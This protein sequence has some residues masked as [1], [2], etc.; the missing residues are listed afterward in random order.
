MTK[1]LLLTMIFLALLVP[2]SFQG[3]RG[4]YETSEGR[5]AECAREMI[6]KGDFLNPTLDYQPH[7]TKPPLTYWT[8][9][10]GIK[11]LGPGEW[12]IRLYASLAFALTALAVAFIGVI[13]WDKTTGFLAGIIYLTS[14]YPA[15]GASTLTTDMLL[16]LWETLAVLCYLRSFRTESSQEGEI[17]I[18]AMWVCFG[19]GFLTKGPPALIPLLPIITW[20]LWHKPETRLSSMKGFLLFAVVGVSW[21]VYVVVRNP[22]LVSYFLGQEVVDRVASSTVHNHEWY[23]PVTMYLPVLI[24]GAGVWLY[25][26]LGTVFQ[27]RIVYPRV[28]WSHLRRGASG[29]FLFFWLV[30]PLILFS[31]V[32]SRL[33]LYV[34]PLYA[35]VALAIAR[36]LGRH[37]ERAGLKRI[38][39]LA[40][41]SALVLVSVK[42]ITAYYPNKNNMRQLY[43]ACEEV[44]GQER[45]FILFDIPLLYGLQYY[46]D[47]RIQRVSL[48]GKETWA[49]ENV[50]D[51]LSK[52]KGAEKLVSCVFIS[53]K[54]KTPALY[55]LLE[56]SDFSYE[57]FEGRYWSLISL[58]SQKSLCL[59]S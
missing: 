19:L 22:E 48:N 17:W 3:A 39:G 16:T 20:H 27:E 13:L 14:P 4:L 40:I 42:G 45:Q 30:F 12:G 11:L 37:L 29:S 32:K 26:G 43:K 24:L 47:G 54:D 38:I 59:G 21:Y 1:N 52:I 31:L 28:L 35:P 51:F 34:L 56:G 44:G 46:L 10:A 41:G 6:E 33:F 53:S 18:I 36:G 49:S 25:F 57:T 7:W 15:L 58:K 8:I 50:E 9:A 23:K 5:Y 2:F 55:R